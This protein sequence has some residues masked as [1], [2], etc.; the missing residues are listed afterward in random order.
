[1]FG[2][3]QLC[4]GQAFKLTTESF[5]E[6][7]SDGFVSEPIDKST[8]TPGKYIQTHI[9]TVVE[10]DQ[11]CSIHCSCKAKEDARVD[12]SDKN[13]HQLNHVK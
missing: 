13:Q 5:Q 1:M 8:E 11:S 9:K 6:D 7:R 3:P 12:S 2:H 4:R 10:T